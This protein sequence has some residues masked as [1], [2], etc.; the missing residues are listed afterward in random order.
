[1]PKS[2]TIQAMRL[3]SARASATF[4]SMAF[5]RSYGEHGNMVWPHDRL[6]ILLASDLT[7]R[8]VPAFDRAVELAVSNA[9]HL[10]IVHVIRDDLLKDVGEIVYGAADEA[11]QRHLADAKA[12]GAANTEAKIILAGHYDQAI[13]EESKQYDAHLVVL[14]SHRERSVQD[15]VLGATMERVLRLGDRPVLVVKSRPRGPYRTILAAVDFSVTSRDAL[16]FAICLLPRGRF[17]VL[18][19]YSG[20]LGGPSEWLGS[21]EAIARKHEMQ[22]D[23]MIETVSREVKAELPGADFTLTAIVDHGDPVEAATRQI[24]RLKPDLV[25]V[26]THGQTGWVRARLGSVARAFLTTMPCDVLAVRPLS[27]ESQR[28]T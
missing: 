2:H 4:H 8:S 5:S 18:N 20:L 10:R 7:A 22:L 16:E 3:G 27:R 23:A 15:V 21:H 28:K 19:V 1:M 11:L 25:V 12:Q 14:G 17:H 9:A 6:R 24:G 26:G 13:I